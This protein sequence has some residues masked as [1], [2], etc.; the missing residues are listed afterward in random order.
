MLKYNREKKR[1]DEAKKQIIRDFALQYNAIKKSELSKSEKRSRINELIENTSNAENILN[2]TNSLSELSSEDKEILGIKENSEQTVD[3]NVINTLVSIFAKRAKM[4]ENKLASGIM[5]EITLRD[6]EELEKIDTQ[7]FEEELRKYFTEHYYDLLDTGYNDFLSE[8][9]AV[10]DGIWNKDYGDLTKLAIKYNINPKKFKNFGYQLT[11]Q[12]G[13]VAEEGNLKVFYATQQGVNK[14]IID[15]YG[16]VLY[17]EKINNEKDVRTDDER[18]L[19]NAYITYA[20]INGFQIEDKDVLEELPVDMKKV[21]GI[22]SYINRVLNEKG[23]ISSDMTEQ[24]SAEIQKEYSKIMNLTFFNFGKLKTVKKLAKG[25]YPPSIYTYINEDSILDTDEENIIYATP[26]YLQEKYTAIMEKIKE[27]SQTDAFLSGDFDI[28]QANKRKDAFRRYIRDNGI[29]GIDISIPKVEIDHKE[30]AIIADAILSRYGANYENKEEMRARILKKV[31]DIYP[32]M[33]YERQVIKLDDLIGEELK[34]MGKSYTAE[35]LYMQRD[36]AYIGDRDG[37]C[38]YATPE[39]I[40]KKIN[41]LDNKLYGMGF[42]EKSAREKLVQ[43]AKENNF[44]I[45]IQNAENVE[46][47]RRW[48]EIF[49]T[50][51]ID[52]IPDDPTARPKLELKDSFNDIV[53]KISEGVP[54]AIVGMAELVKSDETGFV[55]LTVLDDMNIR[56]SQIWQAYK[57]LYN[58]DGKKFA[59]AVKSRDKKMVEFINEEMASVGGEKAVTGGASFDRSKIPDKY[60]FTEEEVEQLKV[61]KEERLK[62]QRETRDKM[63]ANSPAKKKKVGQKRREEREAKKKAYREKLIAKGKK[64]IGELDA[65]LSNLQ[66][67]EKQAQELYNK[68]EKQLE[69]KPKEG[70]DE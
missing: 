18:T 41:A 59:E 30:T 53:Y 66:D 43:Y 69:S 62:I 8:I 35:K 27:L 58:E 49:R 45:Q 11:I 26:E 34:E 31:E 5:E 21:Q 33:I 12:D 22:A 39:G 65:E 3:E 51:D 52:M 9:T 6:G 29:K 28:E 36:F 19:K 2:N 14:R 55:L 37:Q 60:R 57:Y 70:R 48:E 38:I 67:K 20:E 17:R 32:E 46:R 42:D 13:L 15:L 40:E 4:P 1:V 50:T 54:G 56:G 63:I 47:Q 24:F 23:V 7:A 61:Q 68:Y 25:E 16:S 10:P 64:S 44:D